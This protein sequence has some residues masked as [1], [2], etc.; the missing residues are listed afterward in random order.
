MSKMNHWKLPATKQATGATLGQEHLRELRDSLVSRGEDEAVAWEPVILD[1]SGI[2]H[3]NGSY[4]RATYIWL[5]NCGRRWVLD[6]GAEEG[7]DPW[8]EIPLPVVPFVAHLGEESRAEISLYLPAIEA[9]CLEALEWSEQKVTRA[10][11]LK[12]VEPTLFRTLQ[13]LATKYPTTAGELCEAHQSE[14]VNLTAW[15]NRLV[16]LHRS[17]LATREKRGRYWLYR[18][19]FDNLEDD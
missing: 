15:N 8:R 17:L 14:R 1:Y 10:K 6:M 2:E 7:N 18:P 3:I 16:E 4:F 9:P 11:V 19:V 12:R 5:F 13:F